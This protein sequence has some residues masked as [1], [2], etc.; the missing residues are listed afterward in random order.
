MDRP[1]EAF[2]MSFVRPFLWLIA[3][4][5]PVALF[6]LFLCDERLFD[7]RHR[8]RTILIVTLGVSLLAA[9]LTA[10]VVRLF[11][12]YVYRDGL[13]GSGTWIW[14]RCLAWSEIQCVRHLNFV[15]LPYLRIYSH[16]TLTAIWLPLFLT[17]MNRFKEIVAE[18]AE[19][20]NPL[21]E[22]FL[23]DDERLEDGRNTE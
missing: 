8:L 18:H 16:E 7:H 22:Y 9:F 11:K 3:W 2:R 13:C 21:V 19:S 4:D 17:N 12:V 10:P 5:V 14:Y 1:I 20:D 15:G 23:S 6:V